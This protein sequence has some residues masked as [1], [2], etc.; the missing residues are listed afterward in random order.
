MA[1]AYPLPWWLAVLLAAAIAGLTYAEYRRPLVPLS[2]G[3]RATLAACRAT[4][5]ALLVL[6][7]FIH[8][9]MVWRAGFRNRMRAMIRSH[10]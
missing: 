9:V 6:F 5:L 1:F 7:L 8:I 4:T 10:S 2:P 3:Q